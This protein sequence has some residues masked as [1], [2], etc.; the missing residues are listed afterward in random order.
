MIVYSIIYLNLNLW[1]NKWQKKL[2]EQKKIMKN[3]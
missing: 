3:Q 1:E 2:N